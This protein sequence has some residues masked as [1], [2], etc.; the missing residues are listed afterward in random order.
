MLLLHGLGGSK[1][2]WLPVLDALAHRFRVV[3]PDL[4]GHGESEKPATDYTPRFYARVVRR[5]MDELGADQALMV[6]N[7]MGGRVSL[8]LAVRSPNRVRALV[9]LGPAVPGLRWRYLLMFTRIVPTEFGGIPFPLR[10][11]WMQALLRRMFAHP[12]ALS[13]ETFPVASEE[14]IRV[15]RDPAARMAF[16]SSLRHL[17]TDRPDPFW[18]TMRR[19]KQPALVV[20]GEEDR[21]VPPRLASRLAYHLPNARYQALP[22]VGHVPQ[23]EAAQAVLDAIRSFLADEG[24]DSRD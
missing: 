22:E 14:F 11:R 12:D 7:S 5:L 8:E 24:L 13:A 19:V 2:S 16:F 10:D 17:V 1:I 6:G 9:L 4:P 20:T 23:V 18:A 15:Y 3:A 21:L